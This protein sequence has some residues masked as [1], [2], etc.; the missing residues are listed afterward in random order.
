MIIYPRKKAGGDF[1]SIEKMHMVNLVGEMSDFDKLTK[2]L[3][4]EGCMQPV[5]ALQEINS[6]DFVLKTSEGNIEAL[7]DV[8]Y[9]R[10]YLYDKEYNIS[11]KHVEKL[12]KAQNTVGI[13]C[14]Y[15]KEMIFDFDNIEK[16]LAE[17]Y[18]KYTVLNKEFE[19][20]KQKEQYLKSTYE[21]LGFLNAVSIPM[22]E[23]TAMKNFQMNLY[24]VPEQNMVKLKANYENIPSVIETVYKEKDFV[25][26]IAFT[27]MLL[28]TET[29]RIFKSAN[30]E[31][32]LVPNHYIGIPRDVEWLFAKKYIK[33]NNLQRKL[34]WNLVIS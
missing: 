18:D 20:L 7:M 9:I 22:E 30:C 28:L 16:Q 14:E 1:V 24:K 15:I 13:S 26:F 8:N 32:I 12:V 25:I 2:L 21:A 6:S 33:Y 23:I 19:D 3:A 4:L 34:K 5:S 27:P 11:L 10:P 31:K 29:E 17:V